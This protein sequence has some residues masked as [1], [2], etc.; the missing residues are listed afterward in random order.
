MKPRY[1]G[2]FSCCAANVLSERAD[3]IPTGI[4]PGLSK[5][6]ESMMQDHTFENRISPHL[7][8]RFSSEEN[9]NGIFERSVRESIRI[10]E[11]L[12]AAPSSLAMRHEE[13]ELKGPLK[14]YWHVH[15]SEKLT[16]R[17]FNNLGSQ[18]GIINKNPANQELFDKGGRVAMEVQAREFKIEPSSF[19]NEDLMTELLK[20]ASLK[21]ISD[22]VLFAN[23]CSHIGNAVDKTL[24]KSNS[25][26]G[27][28]IIF[29]KNG[30]GVRYY[31]DH[32]EHIDPKDAKAQ[33][34]MKAHLDSLLV[35][36]YP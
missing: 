27:D 12:S 30:D 35:T 18:K 34:E 21:G 15:A 4:G 24:Y 16:A 20:A 2:V 25:V 23:L 7:K 9:K 19:T 17:V 6:E 36:I 32:A 13:R 22:E 14:S 33:A 10:L 5:G 26:T 1:G 28:W 8:S 31:L 11:G 3:E 29:W